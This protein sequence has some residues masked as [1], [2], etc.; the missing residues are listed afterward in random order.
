MKKKTHII[1]A[2]CLL[3]AF[4]SCSS[5]LDKMPD[6]RTVIES[7][8]A[9]KELLVSAY[10]QGSYIA[11]CEAMSDNVGDKSDASSQR[12]LQRN[13]QSYFWRDHTAISQDTHNYFWVNSYSAIGAAN[14]ALEA[15]EDM[16][17]QKEFEP[18]LGEAY[19]TRSYNHF[20]LANI[21]AE[22]YDPAKNESLLGVPYI[23]EAEKEVFVDYER[24]T[25]AKTYELIEKDL[26]AGIELIDNNSYSVRAYHFNS[27]AAYTYASRFYLYTAQWDEV[28]KY[29]NKVLIGD[30]EGKIRKW[31]SEYQGYDYNTLK[32]QYT[33]AEETSNLLLASLMSGY[34][35]NNAF[36]RYGLTEEAS[37]KWFSR[38]TPVAGGNWAYR[39]FGN[40]VA[41]N[42]PKFMEH[43][44]YS[45][46]NATTGYI[47]M[48]FP[49]FTI[50]ETLLNR[51]E[52][53]AMKEDYSNA[54]AD[55][56]LF[57]KHRIKKYDTDGHVVTDDEFVNYY[58]DNE[59]VLTPFYPLNEKQRAYI[60]GI[61]ELRRREFMA[62]GMRWFDVKRFHIQIE[63]VN[64][65]TAAVED[66]LTPDDLRRAVQLPESALSY[67]L[68]PNPR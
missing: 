41:K 32:A 10:P 58:K 6:D 60:N 31:A 44:K 9:V 66:T 23:I 22:H 17:Y 52:A 54:L 64:F 47:Y 2:V 63:R 50:E 19:I 7:P 21:F 56:N 34:P 28:I 36:Y 16:G 5:F 48:M 55:I 38:D 1:S 53:Y 35:R 13:R 43:F 51:A 14:H 18:S 27:D 39:I 24:E 57:F 59:P 65:E 29:A 4:S 15:M 46:I 20:M 68:E 11:F 67:G 61:T 30:F 33:K 37:S 12:D 62:E 25:L 42:I 8:D 45:S 26:L 49:L 40:A 3:A